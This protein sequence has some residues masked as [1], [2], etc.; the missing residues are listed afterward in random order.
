MVIF[1]SSGK[2]VDSGFRPKP[3]VAGVAFS[4]CCRTIIATA[5]QAFVPFRVAR[6]IKTALRAVAEHLAV[7]RG[8]RAA[9]VSQLAIDVGAGQRLERWQRVVQA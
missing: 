2:N 6:V 7:L 4:R 1:D 3:E 9:Q 5:A 8:S